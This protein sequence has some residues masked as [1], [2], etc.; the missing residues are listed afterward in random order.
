[1]A[2]NMPES[3]IQATLIGAEMAVGCFG[4]E[5]KNL[6]ED[7]LLIS[8]RGSPIEGH[9]GSSSDDDERVI[10]ISQTDLATVYDEGFEFINPS[11]SDRKYP[12]VNFWDIEHTTINDN[13]FPLALETDG[14]A[15]TIRSD[16][17]SDDDG[18]SDDDDEEDKSYAGS[19]RNNPSLFLPACWEFGTMIL[20]DEE[21]RNGLTE[22]VKGKVSAWFNYKFIY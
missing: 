21:I 4:D 9:R 13:Y 18:D 20:S 12:V 19:L 16:R 6:V 1:M 8:K 3:A 22:Q 7:P 10:S 14:L 11:I 15:A 5:E 2:T 17:G